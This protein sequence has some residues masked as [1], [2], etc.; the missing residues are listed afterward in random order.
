MKYRT[1]GK[2]GPKVSIICT[3]CWAFGGGAYWGAQDQKDVETVVQSAL[4]EG[5]NLFDNAEMYNDGASETSLGLA[6]GKR[7][8][9]AVIITKAKPSKAYPADLVKSCEGSLRRLKT[10][11]IDIYMFHWPF[12]PISL[13]HFTDDPQIIANPPDPKEAFAAMRALQKQGKIRYIGVSNF[14]VKQLG[15]AG[16]DSGIIMNELPYNLLCRAIEKDIMPECKK[17]GMGIIAYMALQQGLLTGR[18]T[19]ADQ[20]PPPQAH[21]RHFAQ[22][23]GKDFSRH[24]ED[25]AE[26]LTFKTIADLIVIAKDLKLSLPEMSLAW[27]LHKEGISTLLQGSRNDAELAENMKATDIKL[28]AEAIAKMDAASDALLKRLGYSPDYY[29]S[30]ANSRIR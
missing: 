30:E 13:K 11:Y 8:K 5:I 14:G 12:D 27:V 22:S 29:Q 26:D 28:S 4:D 1:L 24:G 9:E 6:L 18:W 19:S 3:G 2:N 20:V 16:P 21:S 15:E 25:G 17:Q 23:R 7:R 10:D